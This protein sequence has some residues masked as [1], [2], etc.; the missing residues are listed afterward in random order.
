MGVLDDSSLAVHNQ[1]KNVYLLSHAS[2][3]LKCGAAAGGQSEC[4]HGGAHHVQ[5]PAVPV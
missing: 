3:W 5:L 1:E 4:V 2:S